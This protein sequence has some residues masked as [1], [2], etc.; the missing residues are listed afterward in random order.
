MMAAAGPPSSS[1][2]L[3]LLEPLEDA[4]AGQSEQ[5]D[6][7]L[8]IAKYV[9]SA[10]VSVRSRLKDESLNPF[11][12][13]SSRLSGEEGRQFVPAVAKHFSR[14]CKSILVSPS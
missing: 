4:A 7:Y 5:T 13:L 8:T 10:G 6:A 12:P 1:S 9:V 3:S 2:L 11:F 14:L